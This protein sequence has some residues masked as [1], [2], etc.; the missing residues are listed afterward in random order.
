MRAK[1]VNEAIKHLKPRSEEEIVK[2]QR[3]FFEE[4]CDIA[5]TLYMDDWESGLYVYNM[6]NNTNY[7]D[8]IDFVYG[9][10]S[11]QLKSYMNQPTGQYTTP[12]LFAVDIIISQLWE[13]NNEEPFNPYDF[14]DK[15]DAMFDVVDESIKHLTPRSEEEIKKMHREEDDLKPDGYMTLSNTGSIQVKLVDGGDSILYRF[16]SEDP[17]TPY[18][19]VDVEWG[20]EEDDYNTDSSGEPESRP[21]FL[22]KDTRYYLDQFMRTDYFHN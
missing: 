3:E 8:L 19:E 17:F 18:K 22:V 21:Y 2:A 16:S 9:E 4:A 20:Y 12:S 14:Y 10:F 13:A 11:D 15:Y 6:S 7:D 5:K 1:T